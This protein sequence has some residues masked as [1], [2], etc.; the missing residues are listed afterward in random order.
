M[1]KPNEVQNKMSRREAISTA[2][3]I[4]ISAVIA[5][6]VA[7]VGGYYAGTQIAQLPE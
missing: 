2:G 7:G 3:K 6:V 1:D 4:A 5:G